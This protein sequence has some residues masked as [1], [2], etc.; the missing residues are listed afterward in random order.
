MKIF[1]CEGKTLFWSN[2]RNISPLCYR[3]YSPC[4]SVAIQLNFR[5]VQLV[6]LVP[7]VILFLFSYDYPEMQKLRI[8]WYKMVLWSLIYR[9]CLYRSIIILFKFYQF[10]IIFSLLTNDSLFQENMSWN[11]VKHWKLDL[12][13][14]VFTTVIMM[15][16]IIRW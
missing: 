12:M 1:P 5:R 2:S 11:C 3:Y 15:F 10:A 16:V 7:Q 9:L 14:V 8:W 6:N 13:D 4:S